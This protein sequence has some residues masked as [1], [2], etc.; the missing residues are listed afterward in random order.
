[1]T[2][3]TI[4][5]A[6]VATVD[7]TRAPNPPKAGKDTGSMDK[8][9]KFK[10]TIEDE[11]GVPFLLSKKELQIDEEYQREI[12]ESKVLTIAANWSWMACGALLVAEREPGEFFVFDGGHRR[13]AAMRLS[14]IDE[15]PCVVFKLNDKCKEALAFVRA[16]CNRKTMS[17]YHK[18][19][20]LLAG[21][22]IV[23]Q[24]AVALM[25][26]TGFRPAKSGAAANTVVCIAAFMSA[27]RAQRNLLTSLWPLLSKLHH[28]LV[29]NERVLK[30]L[31]YIAKYGSEDITS[32]KWEERILQIGF[33]IIKQNIDKEAAARAA[34]GERIWALGL[35]A[36][37][38]KGL[39]NNKIKL[40]EMDEE[41]A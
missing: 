4:D 36:V 1:M 24:D 23:A 37:L 41:K 28:G 32:R 10:W 9:E 22:D 34:G 15:L 13:E 39:R 33:P 19:R 26:S 35:V 14:K 5:K 30:A 16:N 21:R 27:F 6:G 17:S 3:I 20:A 18:L 12:Y 11:P 25:Q 38:N 40:R 2:T 8:A 29:L 7:K 31:L